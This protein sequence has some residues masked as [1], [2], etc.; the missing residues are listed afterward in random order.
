D[1]RIESARS[2]RD[3]ATTVAADTGQASLPTAYVLYASAQL[4]TLVDDIDESRAKESLSDHPEHY[5][6]LFNSF[7]RF[8][9]LAFEMEKI[10]KI[11]RLRLELHRQLDKDGKPVGSEGMEQIEKRLKLM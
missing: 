4:R 1:R 7:A 5:A 6:K 10:E 8:A 3:W 9:K 11:I 2:L